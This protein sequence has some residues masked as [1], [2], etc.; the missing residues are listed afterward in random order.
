MTC[1]SAVLSCVSDRGMSAPRRVLENC[2]VVAVVLVL[3]RV[4]LCAPDAHHLIERMRWFW[5]PDRLLADCRLEFRVKAHECHHRQLFIR[6][7]AASQA[8][9]AS[10]EQIS[11]AAK[12][13]AL[14][15]MHEPRRVGD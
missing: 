5:N 3:V 14:Q 10:H 8:V 6:G 12:L 15:F 7:R 13:L 1:L 2:C 9:R 11:T 4:E